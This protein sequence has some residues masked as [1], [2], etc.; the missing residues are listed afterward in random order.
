MY[1]YCVAFLFFLTPLVYGAELIWETEFSSEEGLGDGALSGQEGWIGAESWVVDSA[2]GIVALNEPYGELAKSEAITLAAYDR[3]IMVVTVQ[4]DLSKDV[5]QT[6]LRFG[7]TTSTDDEG[8]PIALP[9]GNSSLNATAMAAELFRSGYPFLQ[10]VGED[11]HSGTLIFSPFSGAADGVITVAGNQAGIYP[12][13]R[14]QV[15]T[16]V[17]G[18]ADLAQNEAQFFV[19]ITPVTGVPFGTG[20]KYRIMIGDDQTDDLNLAS[21][22]LELQEAL[23]KLPSIGVGNITVVGN[24]TEGFKLTF[25]GA[26][27]ADDIAQIEVIEPTIQDHVT[28]TFE[29]TY[30]LLKTT[31]NRIFEVKV[32]AQNLDTAEQFEAPAQELVDQFAHTATRFYPALRGGNL[33]DGGGLVIKRISLTKEHGTGDED[34]DGFSNFAEL[35]FG[36]DYQDA[37]DN[38]VSAQVLKSDFLSEI[39][40]SLNESPDWFADPFWLQELGAGATLIGGAGARAI[41]ESSVGIE[42]GETSWVSTEFRLTDLANFAVEDTRVFDLG[43]TDSSDPAVAGFRI[44]AGVQA[45]VTENGTL[46]LDGL[47][48]G[49]VSQIFNTAGYDSVSDEV[50]VRGA[51]RAL[52]PSDWIRLEVAMTKGE[53]EGTWMVKKQL[54]DLEG[55]EQGRWES[56]LEIVD[57]GL[58]NAPRVRAGFGAAEGGSSAV[59]RGLEVRNFNFQLIREGDF[60]SD[61]LSN[62]EE[63]FLGTELSDVD[64][65]HDGQA[66]WYEVTRGTDP[67]DASSLVTTVPL[68]LQSYVIY[69]WGQVNMTVAGLPGARVLIEESNDLIDWNEI[70][71]SQKSVNLFGES[72]LTGW[73]FPTEKTESYYRVAIA[74]SN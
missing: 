8:N 26:L 59:V 70:E 3:L 62:V 38:P 45:T 11:H 72:E 10:S 5:N 61:R 66:D 55:V 60:E 53:S 71:S 65:D 15:L 27:A 69:Q 1:M 35:Y 57:V 46:F 17:N 9:L 51:N 56:E 16:M 63:F 40:F 47:E 41:T 21:T 54:T 33:Q 73:D 6:P 32:S 34:E 28:Q 24:F 37:G 67:L 68:Q 30:E 2:A 31:S 7:F 50:S 19:P 22:R 13:A 18:D 49:Q 48:L 20:D 14:F 74:P 44:V 4:I 43:F 58:W 39:E 52:G 25:T 12:H 29:L 64:S 36:S 42:E 23:E